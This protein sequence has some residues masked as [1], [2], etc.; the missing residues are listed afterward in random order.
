MTG[1]GCGLVMTAAARKGQLLAV[2]KP[3]AVGESKH[4]GMVFD[5]GTGG[6]VQN[7]TTWAH[8][9]VATSAAC[10]ECS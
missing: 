8:S 9:F 2:C 7:I 10:Q 3:V 1:Q 6:M 5:H 4:A